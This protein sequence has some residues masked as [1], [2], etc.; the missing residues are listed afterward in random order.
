M[1]LEDDLYVQLAQRLVDLDLD[2]V[3]E[4]HP[5]VQHLAELHRVFLQKRKA[6]SH[7]S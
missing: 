4:D 3:K 2:D 1:K 5:I 7:G 6:K